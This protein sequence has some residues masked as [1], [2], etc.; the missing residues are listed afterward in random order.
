[1]KKFLALFLA[2]IT[3]LSVSLVACGKK[4]GESTNTTAPN[5]DLWTGAP[6]EPGTDSGSDS[7]PVTTLPPVDLPYTEDTARTTIYVAYAGSCKL[8]SSDSDSAD[9]AGTANFKDSFTRVKYNDYWTV[10]DINGTHKYIKTK[11]VTTDPKEITFTD[12]EPTTVYANVTKDLFLRW[13]IWSEQTAEEQANIGAVVSR[14]TAL[15]KTGTTE[16]GWIRVTYEGKTLYCNGSL[17]STE[18]PSDDTGTQAP[19]TGPS[20]AD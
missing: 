5:D 19:S 9:S 16:K 12:V 1:M 18:V 7:T 11:F 6:I 15:T 10:V 14:G 4:D 3:I 20:V 8:R 13:C 2:L 17:V